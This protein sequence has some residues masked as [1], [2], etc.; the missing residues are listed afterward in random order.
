M[1]REQNANSSTENSSYPPISVVIVCMDASYELE[2]KL[3]LILEQEYENYE[4]II[5]DN[6]STDNTK[7]VLLQ[8]EQ[9]Y[10]RLRHTFLPSTTRY[11]SRQKMAMTLGI[12]SAKY[13]WVVITEPGSSPKSAL[14][15]KSLSHYMTDD[16][17]II[18]GYSNYENTASFH[19][20]YARYNRMIRQMRYFSAATS[21]FRK[22][23]V[24][25][26]SANLSI[27][28]SMFLKKKGFSNNLSL[29]RGEDILLVDEMAEKGRV[30]IACTND[31]AVIQSLSTKQQWRTQLIVDH[32]TNKHISKRGRFLCWTWALSSLFY[33]IYVSGFI[34][35][36]CFFLFY[37]FFVY[38]AIL[39]LFMVL[40]SFI[41]YLLIKNSASV[42][43]ERAPFFLSNYYELVKPWFSIRDSINCYLNK[44]EFYRKQ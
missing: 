39:F 20:K 43:H 30:A 31:A 1:K 35:I 6:A 33:Y 41:R 14:W 27:R 3:P 38:A 25:G 19:S 26:L 24:G 36:I 2:K 13:E 40:N 44:E 11:L 34:S 18:L 12:R 42:Y 32:E 9:K 16:N 4:V 37:E 7:D 15:L 29:L 10:K 21:I 5:V 8:L 23:A 22:K 17:D 28:K